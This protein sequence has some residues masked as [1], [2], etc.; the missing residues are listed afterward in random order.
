MKN[1]KQEEEE[2][3]IVEREFKA[4]FQTKNPRMECINLCGV[5]K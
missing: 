1:G 3:K 2:E 4:F 5:E